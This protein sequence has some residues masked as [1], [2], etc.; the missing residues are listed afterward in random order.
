MV[1]WLSC[2][3]FMSIFVSIVN[4][5]LNVIQC[6]WTESSSVHASNSR[7]QSQVQGGA[8]ALARRK[9]H[10]LCGQQT[11]DRMCSGK[12]KRP[13]PVPH[14]KHNESFFWWVPVFQPVSSKPLNATCC[15]FLP[16][17]IYALQLRSDFIASEAGV[18]PPLSAQEE[19]L[20]L[21]V[22]DL[23]RM[24]KERHQS[25]KELCKAVRYH[26]P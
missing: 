1:F 5:A 18:S 22:L 15:C 16:V 4:V 24:A 19:C 10:L 11:N 25:V 23:W 8:P 13:H 17:F 14:N 26:S 3:C 9:I 7:R 12:T 20:G 6:L 2:G 21:A